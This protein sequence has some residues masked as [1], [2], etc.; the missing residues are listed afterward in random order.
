MANAIYTAAKTAMMTGGLNLLAD[1]I[2]VALVDGAEYV[3]NAGHTSLAD[4]PPAARVAVATLTGKSVTAGVFDANDAIFVA[5]SGAQSECLILYR[6]S[7]N[8]A[9]S[10]LIGYIDTGS[11]LP[12][13]P[14]G[15][16]LIVVWPNDDNKIIKL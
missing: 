3:F 5:A 6:D 15:F 7:G 11:G 1:T 14:T 4:V 2:R 16:D 10:T 12:V 8:E 13:T 9:T